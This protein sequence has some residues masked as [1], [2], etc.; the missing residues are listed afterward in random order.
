MVPGLELEYWCWP[1]LQTQPIRYTSTSQ[2]DYVAQA[3]TIKYVVSGDPT[4]PLCGWLV[5]GLVGGL[6][7]R[8]TTEL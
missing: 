7:G 1:G 5:G 8:L 3:T 2:Q 4:L 6:V